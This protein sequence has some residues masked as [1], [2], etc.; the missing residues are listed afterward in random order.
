M[1][2]DDLPTTDRSSKHIGCK[3]LQLIT[4]QIFFIKKILIDLDDHDGSA[5]HTLVNWFDRSL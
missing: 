4:N 1:F 2:I 3:T 5:E